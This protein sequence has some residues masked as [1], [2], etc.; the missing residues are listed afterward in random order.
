[1][2][3]L[4]H[5]HTTPLCQSTI[6]LFWLEAGCQVGFPPLQGCGKGTRPGDVVQALQANAR[7]VAHYVHAYQAVAGTFPAPVLADLR[8]DF[9]QGVAP[10]PVRCAA[11][12]RL[13]F[14]SIFCAGFSVF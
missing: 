7:Q 8:D 12:I 4:V 10:Q 5:H 6:P 3:W 9:V 14:V 11:T 1:M 13:V 2:T